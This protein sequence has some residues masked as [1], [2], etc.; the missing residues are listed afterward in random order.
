MRIVAQRVGEA[1]V[2]VEGETIAAIGRG[3]LI[4]AGV[5]PE[6]TEE[7]AVWL[8]GKLARLRIFS[9]AGGKM[10]L[11][12][13]DIGGEAL[14]VSQFTLFA[15]TAKGNRPSFSAA[16]GPEKAVTLYEFL[17]G[18]L[19]RELGRPVARGRF[20]ADMAVSLR[21]EGPVTIIMDSKHRE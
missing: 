9:D 19:S 18:R 20:G 13:A 16:A 8:A 21:N 3:L 14:V 15:E 10:N 12:V 17:A 7:D 4:L 11:S 2:T 6:D 5:S 1:S